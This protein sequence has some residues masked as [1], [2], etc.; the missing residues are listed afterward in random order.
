MACEHCITGEETLGSGK[1]LSLKQIH[2]LDRRG[3]ARTWE[4]AQRSGV[5]GAVVL[6]AELV[7]S[8]KYLLIRQFRP[9]TGRYVIE[10]PA[11]LVDPGETVED[12]ACRE[13]YEETGYRGTVRRM[14]PMCCSS[15]GM[16]GEEFAAARMVIDE[17]A[18]PSNPEQHLEGS[19]D[20]ERFAL[21]PGEI[22]DFLAQARNRGDAVDGKVEFFFAAA[23]LR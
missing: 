9:A 2:Y 6:I 23:E 13:L 4:A 22:P 16:T 21:L 17:N 12:T 20:I 5:R 3:V 14:L 10:F 18:N 11:G 1:F 15:P 19:E 8:G 7:P